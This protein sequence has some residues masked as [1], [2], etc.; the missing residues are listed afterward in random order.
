M[1]TDC[2]DHPCFNSSGAEELKHYFHRKKCNWLNVILYKRDGF[3]SAQMECLVKRFD[4]NPCTSG[5]FFHK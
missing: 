4:F 3:V 2:Q 1:N 5:D